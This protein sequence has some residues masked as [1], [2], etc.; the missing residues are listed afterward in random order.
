MLI[1]LACG[2]CF[3]TLGVVFGFFLMPAEKNIQ[4]G[5]NEHKGDLIE[6]KNLINSA[7]ANCK[8]PI[9]NQCEAGFFNYKLTE[10]SSFGEKNET[11]F[12][13]QNLATGLM[14][15]EKKIKKKFDFV[16]VN[17]TTVKII[18]NHGEVLLVYQ[19]TA[20]VP[21]KL[22]YNYDRWDYGLYRLG[23]KWYYAKLEGWR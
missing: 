18:F 20:W 15:L 6:L 12:I 17:R 1:T 5:F 10:I 2:I 11:I 19:D 23:D 22:L 14:E 21:Q 4:D 13:H 9:N 8:E 7:Y 3:S 16:E